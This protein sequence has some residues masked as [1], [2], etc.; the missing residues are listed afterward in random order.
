MKKVLLILL[1]IIIIP[2]EVQAKQKVKVYIFTKENEEYSDAA[3]NYFKELKETELGEYFEYKV[4]E[5]WDEDW[6]EDSYKRKIADKV[7]GYFDNTLTGAPYIVISNKYNA[8]SFDI[9]N[10]EDIELVIKEAYEKKQFNDL[11]KVA[12]DEIK[13]KQK[14]DTI[15]FVTITLVTIIITGSFIVL[16]RKSND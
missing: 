2:L 5:V 11:V 15:A 3:V 7:A 16:A 10:T 9:D 6:Q 13:E 1:L 12:K 14:K 4:I 8:S